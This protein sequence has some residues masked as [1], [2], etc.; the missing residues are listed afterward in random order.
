VI[1]EDE[2]AARRD[3]LA[4]EVIAGGVVADVA[5]DTPKDEESV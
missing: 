2:L 5:A 3:G 4:G 1:L